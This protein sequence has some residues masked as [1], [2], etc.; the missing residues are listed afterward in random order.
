MAADRRLHQ[1]T[2]CPTATRMMLATGQASNLHAGASAA[3]ATS[4][5]RPLPLRGLASS[6]IHHGQA[7]PGAGSTRQTPTNCSH[8]FCKT[9]CSA[10]TNHSML[11]DH[12][13]KVARTGTDPALVR[14][15]GVACQG[16]YTYKITCREEWN[17]E[18]LQGMFIRTK[19]AKYKNIYTPTSC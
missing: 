15:Q 19:Q 1:T 8:H 5:S 9:C 7:A 12:Q 4:G 6:A 17:W 14:S 3:H 18:S 16:H 11:T 2:S 13:R 10:S